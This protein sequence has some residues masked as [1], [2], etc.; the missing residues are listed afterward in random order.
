MLNENIFQILL[1]E[2]D[3]EP[4]LPAVMQRNVESLQE[5]HPT[6]K[7]HRLGNADIEALIGSNFGSDVLTAYRTL[8]PLCYRADLA[9]FCLLLLHGGIYA[10]MAIR[11]LSPIALPK[12]KQMMCFRDTPG[13]GLWTVSTSLIAAA[14]GRNEF[15][16]AIEMLCKNVR[17]RHYGANALHPTGPALFGRALAI[18]DR[19]EDIDVGSFEF[20]ADVRN[21]H[22]IG[23]VDSS[24]RIVSLRMKSGSFVDFGIPGTND[25]PTLWNARQVYGEEGA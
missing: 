15:R 13:T 12:G 6:F 8:R 11:L 10:D 21:A 20:L 4:P 23:H 1:T 5:H 19:S 9:R 22:N 3:G 24:G 7:Y 14:A 16:I 18:E 17:E 25:Y 2:S